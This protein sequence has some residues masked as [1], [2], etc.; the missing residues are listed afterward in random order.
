LG[1]H[2]KFPDMAVRAGAEKRGERLIGRRLL[3]APRWL[4]AS[5][6]YLNARG[7]PRTVRDLKD[8]DCVILGARAE[9]AAWKIYVGK[10]IQTVMVRGRVA[11]NEATLATECV[12]DGFGIGFLPRALCAKY[13]NAGTLKRVLPNASAGDSGL[14]LV[15]PDRHLPTPS[16][17]LVDFL[18]KEL[19]ASFSV[20][21]GL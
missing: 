12:V 21:R 5:P 19:P 6:R 3:D 1:H 8:H 10:R 7:T 20:G 2:F 16:R 15:Y 4:F 14:W 11:V 17:A 9:R 18:L 13:V